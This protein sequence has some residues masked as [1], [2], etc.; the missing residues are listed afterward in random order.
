VNLLQSIGLLYDREVGED[1]VE[2]IAGVYF[3]IFQIIMTFLV[4]S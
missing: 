2:E 4:G 3:N 1:G